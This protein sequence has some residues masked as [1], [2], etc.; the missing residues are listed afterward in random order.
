MIRRPP[1]STLFPYTT[2][3]RSEPRR[4]AHLRPAR[5]EVAALLRDVLD[6]HQRRAAPLAPDREALQ[7]TQDHQQDG[8][9]DAYRLEGGQEPYKERRP[10]HDEQRDNEHRL[11]PHAVPEVPEDHAAHGPGEEADAE[12][13]EG[14][15]R[16]RERGEL[17]EE[18]PVEDQRGGGP[19]EE[20]VVPLYG[21]PDKAREGDLP[22]GRATPDLLPPEPLHALSHGTNY[23]TI[24]P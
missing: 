18:E 15:Q 16:P 23:A 19:V 6:G 9:P 20:E 2:L 17:W 21:G 12:G 24:L 22:D 14:G 7:E 8:G 13:R 10:T 1:R 3:F 11:A 5:V 4:G